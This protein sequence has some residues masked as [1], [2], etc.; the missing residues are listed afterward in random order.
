MQQAA[1]SAAL[2]AGSRVEASS[3]PS[4]HPLHKDICPGCQS[5]SQSTSRFP[6]GLCLLLLCFG[7]SGGA[8]SCPLGTCSRGTGAMETIKNDMV[9]D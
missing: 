5:G 6:W 3:A 8:A 4:V 2:V 1:C 7:S 9:N